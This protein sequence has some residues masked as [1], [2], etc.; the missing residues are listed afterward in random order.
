M[1][2]SS[3][4]PAQDAKPAAE[5]KPEQPAASDKKPSALEEDDEFEDF[6]VD[7]TI[8]NVSCGFLRRPFSLSLVPF[9]LLPSFSPISIRAHGLLLLPS[10]AS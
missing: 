4:T 7:G 10:M 8:L 6:P 5:H 3:T 1:A 9:A 2:S